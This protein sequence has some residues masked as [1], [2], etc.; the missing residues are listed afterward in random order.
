MGIG[1]T[2]GNQGSRV[3]SYTATRE[4]IN[5]VDTG[6]PLQSISAMPIYEDKSHEELRFEDYEFRKTGKALGL[7]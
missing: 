1:P 7:S 3:A 5:G 4:V 2:N 6:I